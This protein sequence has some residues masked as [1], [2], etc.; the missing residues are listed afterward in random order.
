M[1]TSAIIARFN[2][3]V[4]DASELSSDEEL[5]LA[6]ET[7]DEVC[8]DRPWE[9]L[10]SEYSGTTSTSVPYI[11]LPADFRELS[12]NKNQESI[13]FVGS[14]YREYKVVPFSSR[15][16]YRDMSGFC[17]IDIPNQRLYF[18]KQPT[19]AEAVEYDYIKIPDALTTATAPVV[20]TNQFG[21]LIAY[22]MARRFPSIEQ[23][24][25]GMSY[26]SENMMEYE[27]ILT[28]LQKED[29]NIKLGM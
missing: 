5:A 19:T 10:K 15:R 4:D 18:T 21:N 8:S 6:Q 22:G 12:P 17:Y 25:K 9:W 20:T 7:Y 3:Q 2:V 27:R 1:L 13:I 24:E 11:A 26:S 28:V 23:A 16:E 29:A 14:D